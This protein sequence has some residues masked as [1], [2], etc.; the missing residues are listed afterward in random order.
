MVLQSVLCSLQSPRWHSLEQYLATRHPEH[1]INSF[2]ASFLS[3]PQ[4]WHSPN[5]SKRFEELGTNPELI[6]AL[7]L[8]LLLAA[9]EDNISGGIVSSMKGAEY[10][11]EIAIQVAYH[12]NDSYLGTAMNFAGSYTFQQEQIGDTTSST[13]KGMWDFSPYSQVNLCSRVIKRPTM[14]RITFP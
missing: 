3:L 8:D 13:D 10:D 12:E 7:E 2:P 14:A 9:P 1:F 6:F 11:G 5:P 4:L